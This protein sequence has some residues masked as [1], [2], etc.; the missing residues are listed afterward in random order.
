YASSFIMGGAHLRH[1]RSLD[2]GLHWG[3]DHEIGGRGFNNNFFSG[4]PGFNRER[5]VAFVSLA[6]DRSTGPSAGRLHAVWHEMVAAQRDPLGTGPVV[7]EVEPDDDGLS[8]VPFTP[9]ASLRGVMATATDFDWWSFTGVAGQTFVAQ[10]SRTTSNTS[11]GFLRRYAGGGAVN[12]RCAFSHLGAGG[13]VVF[14][15]PSDGTYR[16][17]V[18]NWDG[19]DATAGG[20]RIDTAWH[21]PGPDDHARDQRDVMYSRSDNGGVTWTTPVL[22]SDTPPGLDETFPEVAVDDA[23][24]VHVVWYD[25]REDPVNGI[26]TSMRTRMSGD[27][28]GTWSPSQRVDDAPAV[29][30]NLVQ[31][32]MFP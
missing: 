26:L 23:G 7:T 19:V 32:N 29:N 31:S 9:G 2:H 28:G 4:P 25:H 18:L 3:P 20:Y 15:L 13:A 21:T 12:T 11:N 6:V 17:R 16:L 14:T 1:R 5:A 24:R 10:L 8:A 22:L 27:G 30:W